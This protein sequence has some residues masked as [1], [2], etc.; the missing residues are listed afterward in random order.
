[1]N[2]LPFQLMPTVR[3]RSIFLHFRV[4]RRLSNGI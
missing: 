4:V 3:E 2:A 1:M